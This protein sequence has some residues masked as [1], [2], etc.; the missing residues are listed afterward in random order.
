MN[1][2]TASNETEE[3]EKTEFCSWICYSARNLND[4]RQQ[5]DKVYGKRFPGF[6]LSFDESDYEWQTVSRTFIFYV[7]LMLPD[8]IELDQQTCSMN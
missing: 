6:Y 5:M 3:N 7:R 2:S 8:Y 4:Y 1:F